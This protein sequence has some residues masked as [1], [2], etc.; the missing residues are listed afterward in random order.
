MLSLEFSKVTSLE[1]G[2]PY[3]LQPSVDVANPSFEG[4]T[5]AVTA[6]VDQTSDAN[7]SF[8]GTFAPTELAGGNKN[9]LFLGAG[10]EL[11]WPDATGNLKAF[12]AYFEVKGGA[13]KVAK[14]ARIVQKG[15]QTQ[16]IDLV[17]NPNA[18]HKRII[19]G[20]LVIEKNGMLFNAQGQMVK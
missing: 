14:R 5:I 10:N 4:V 18:A 19:D 20:Q 2:K 12:R 1:A 7:I 11:F 13:A 3:L 16:A 17:E 6:P 8:H 15:E 9:L